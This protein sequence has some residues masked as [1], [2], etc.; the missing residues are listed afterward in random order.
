MIKY[1]YFKMRIKI[2]SSADS[3][4]RRQHKVMYTFEGRIQSGSKVGLQLWVHE[5]EFIPVLL[6]INY[7]TNFHTNNYKPTFA[8]PSIK[9]WWTERDLRTIGLVTWVN[10]NK[11]WLE[12][13]YYEGKSLWYKTSEKYV[14]ELK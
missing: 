10:L 4:C 9:P 2:L 6:F 8:P 3:Q 13:Q 12:I 1:R 14:I 7:S 11:H 5:T